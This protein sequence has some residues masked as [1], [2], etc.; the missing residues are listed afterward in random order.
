MR[1][2]MVSEFLTLD[3]VMEASE[4]WQP[5]YVSDDIAEEIRTSIHASEAFLLGRVTYEM[6]AAYWPLQ[7]NNE[8]GIADKLNSG[9]KFVV[10]STLQRV[11]W[12]NS[13]LIKGNP[14]EKVRELKQQPGGNITVFGSGTLVQSL[15]QAGLIDEYR[16]MVH[17]IVLGRG[18]RLFNDGMEAT[19]LGLVEAQAFNSGVVLLRYQTANGGSPWL[20]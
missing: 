1:K 18:K 12:N 14:A 17:P 13:T 5:P 7:T 10:S 15:M 16:L 19:G 20:S 8:F 11:E 6:F 9:R 3:G 2:V 4:E